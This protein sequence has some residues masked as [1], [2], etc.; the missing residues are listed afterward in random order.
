MNITLLRRGYGNDGLKTHI[1]YPE[2]VLSRGDV[3][4]KQLRLVNTDMTL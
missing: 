4:S 2:L 3:D 1:R